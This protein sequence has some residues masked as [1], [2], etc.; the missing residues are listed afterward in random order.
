MATKYL[1]QHL[2]S[3][4]VAHFCLIYPSKREYLL[5]HQHLIPPPLDQDQKWQHSLEAIII[6]REND[7]H[8]FLP[9]AFYI[10][11]TLSPS[12]YVPYLARLQTP[13]QHRL[14]TG[15]TLFIADVTTG[16][17]SQSWHDWMTISS[18]EIELC[19]GSRF[20]E[21]QRALRGANNLIRLFLDPFPH[22][23]ME[24][25]VT[26]YDSPDFPYEN[27]CNDC[28]SDWRDSEIEQYDVLW[29]ELPGYFWLGSWENIHGLSF[30][31]D[32]IKGSDTR[33]DEPVEV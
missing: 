14:L 20:R 8:G 26:D 32:L 19:Q 27:I 11:S 18:C 3:E 5:L 4:V 10:A 16:M 17:T 13:D 25:F 31:N 15:P 33:V 2:R 23:R 1:C 21:L 24:N 22:L 30:T 12:A 28:Y 9:T 7:V 6:A 29:A